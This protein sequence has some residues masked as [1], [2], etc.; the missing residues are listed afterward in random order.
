MWLALVLLAVPVTAEE[1]P[2]VSRELARDIL[3]LEEKLPEPCDTGSEADQIN[4]LIA[5]RYAKDSAAAKVATSL[6]A[7]SGTVMGI[8]PEQDFDGAYRGKLHLVPHLPIAGDRKHLEWA[9]GALVDF[10]AFFK[11][12]GGK[13]NYRWRALDFR[14]FESVKRR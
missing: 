6:Y 14:F 10:E 4:C 1:T 12:L 7:S 2:K 9:A 11:A 3:F 8:L 5:A 13:P